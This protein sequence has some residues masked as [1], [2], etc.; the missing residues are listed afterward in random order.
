MNALNGKIGA[1]L[2]VLHRFAADGKADGSQISVG[3][4]TISLL[5]KTLDSIQ[6]LLAK[7]QVMDVPNEVNTTFPQDLDPSLFDL[8]QSVECRLCNVSFCKLFICMRSLFDHVSLSQT[9]YSFCLLK[10]SIKLDFDAVH[11][12]PCSRTCKPRLALG[13]FATRK[14]R[15]NSVTIKEQQQAKAFCGNYLLFYFVE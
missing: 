12:R 9:I 13:S 1:F 5:D 8:Q 10:Y 7:S 4:Q 6:N 3:N 15:N 2:H 11:T 14:E